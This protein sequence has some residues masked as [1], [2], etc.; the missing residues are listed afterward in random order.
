M[1]GGSPLRHSL[2]RA[3]Q[4]RDHRVYQRTVRRVA[5]R[6]GWSEE[7]LR[8]AVSQ[9]LGRTRGGRRISAR[10]EALVRAAGRDDHQGRRQPVLALVEIPQ[11]TPIVLGLTR[12]GG[13]L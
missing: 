3:R 5:L 8:K 13:N 10:A 2:H 6:G 11:Q 9:G 4:Q 1:R 12:V 7:C